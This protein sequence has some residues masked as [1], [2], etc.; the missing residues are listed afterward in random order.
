MAGGSGRGKACT[1]GTQ[2]WAGA[3]DRAEQAILRPGT[4]HNQN[5]FPESGGVHALQM[6][7]S[8]HPALLPEERL[9][10]ARM[11]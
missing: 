11:D 9:R 1:H 6:I 3:I 2:P 10:L 7:K 5:E 8:D 4:L